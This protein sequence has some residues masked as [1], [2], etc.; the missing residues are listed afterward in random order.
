MIIDSKQTEEGSNSANNEK[1][2]LM[3]KDIY[4]LWSKVMDYVYETNNK[5]GPGYRLYDLLFMRGVI[6]MMKISEENNDIE[7]YNKYKKRFDKY[8]SEMVNSC[9]NDK[10]GKA[11]YIGVL[12]AMYLMHGGGAD[13]KKS[14]GKLDKAYKILSKEIYDMNAIGGSREQRFVFD[15][16]YVDLLLKNN[17]MKQLK[18]YLDYFLSRYPLKS[19]EIIAANMA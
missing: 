10:E 18:E 4:Q 13:N 8:K 14:K 11:K 5:V 1:Y 3:K 19:L 17:K 16:M 15:Q 9:K 12:D 2:V 6:Q 7:T